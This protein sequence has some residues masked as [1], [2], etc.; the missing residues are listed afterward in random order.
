MLQSDIVYRFYPFH[1]G[2]GILNIPTASI[3][4]TQEEEFLTFEVD[5][6]LDKVRILKEATTD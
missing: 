4:F 5:A 3:R 2:R 1:P 6:D